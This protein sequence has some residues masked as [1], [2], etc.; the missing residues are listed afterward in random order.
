MSRVQVN[1]KKFLSQLFS[2]LNIFSGIGTATII[3]VT[4]INWLTLETITPQV[5]QAYVAN[6]NV[7]LS[8]QL[9]ETYETLLVRGLA[10]ARAAVQRSFDKDILITE[11]KVTISGENKGAIAPIMIVEVSRQEWNKIPEAK[12]WV[13]YIP[14]ADIL[15][16]F[17][18]ATATEEDPQGSPLNSQPPNLG[19][20]PPIPQGIPPTEENLNAP[21]PNIPRR[22]GEPPV[23]I[24]GSNINTPETLTTPTSEENSTPTT[25][26]ESENNSSSN[27]ENEAFSPTESSGANSNDADITINRGESEE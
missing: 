3:G 9:G 6:V 16:G 17:E 14:N 26:S 25:T 11:V 5:A 12:S 20:P 15:L 19:N 2:K 21:P 7:N 24:P 18:N 8:R 23:F 22:L 27:S 10:V 13:S 1:N 4:G